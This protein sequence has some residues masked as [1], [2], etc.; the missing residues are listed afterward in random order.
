MQ[1][2]RTP[3]AADQVGA[4]WEEMKDMGVLVGK[5]GLYGS[6]SWNDESIALQF[7]N[8]LLIQKVTKVPVLVV[9]FALH[10]QGEFLIL[11]VL[12]DKDSEVSISFFCSNS[13]R[14]LLWVD[15][16]CITSQLSS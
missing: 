9:T 4:I 6:V 3:L 15:W 14:L 12:V 2:S 11:K 10:A 13:A 7:L 8:T 1:E 5:G 16:Q